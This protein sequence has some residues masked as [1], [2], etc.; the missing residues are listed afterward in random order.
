MHLIPPIFRILRPC[1]GKTPTFQIVLV[2][3][4]I[5]EPSH[6]MPRCT[7]RNVTFGSV[8]THVSAGLPTHPMDCGHLL[9][10]LVNQLICL[11]DKAARE[12]YW[13]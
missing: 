5:L 13:I 6:K 11:E 10:P 3:L 4:Q 12:Q 7:R 8:M 9:T 1:G 2:E